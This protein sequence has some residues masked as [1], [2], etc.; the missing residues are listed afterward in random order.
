MLYPIG[1]FILGEASPVP[2]ANLICAWNSESVVKSGSPELVSQLNAVYGTSNNATQSTDLNKPKWLSNQINGYPAL[3]MPDGEIRYMDFTK[4]FTSLSN[5]TIYFVIKH[6]QNSS[7]NFNRVF[8]GDS[9]VNEGQIRTTSATTGYAGWGVSQPTMGN[10]LT[11]EDPTPSAWKYFTALPTNLYQNGVEETYAFT[12][13]PQLRGLSR[14][15]A[16][17]GGTV[18]SNFTGYMAEILVYS[19]SHDTTTRQSIESYISNK[20]NF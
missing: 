15:F 2:T 1:L 10:R 20:Y 3:H 7:T 4:I 5:F 18:G 8:S 11:D 6:V 9:T 14:L 19:V 16:S 13:N 17:V 12:N